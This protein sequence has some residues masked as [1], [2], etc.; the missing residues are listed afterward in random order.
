[1]R[2]SFVPPPEVREL[3]ELTRYRER[4]A[5]SREELCRHESCP[6]HA[7]SITRPTREPADQ[8]PAPTPTVSATSN[9]GLSGFDGLDH[10]DQR[11]ADSGHQFN[12]EPP[13]QALCVGA[14]FVFEA[15]NDA[16]AV[17]D[18]VGSRLAGPVSNNRF[19]GLPS[20]IV[21]SP[22]GFAFGPFVSDPRCYFDP[23]TQRWF[24]TVLELDLNPTA[25][26]FTGPSSLLIAV[27]T[28]SDPTGQF[29][30]YRLDTTDR[31]DGDCPCF[32]DFPGIGADA[33]GFYI[34][35]NEYPVSGLRPNVNKGA[36]LFA[37][38]K[39]ALESGT[40][41]PV[42][43]LAGF[44]PND[45]GHTIRPAASPGGA[46]A[47]ANGGTEY[48]VSAFPI[49]APYIDNRIN[50][51]SLTNT[52]SLGTPTPAL[53]LS[54]V[55]VTSEMTAQPAEVEQR[56]GPLPLADFIANVLQAKPGDA[57]EQHLE[58]LEGVFRAPSQV[59]YS[60]G[61]LWTAMDTEVKTP[62]GPVRMGAAW[63]VIEPS[64]ATGSLSAR[65]VNQ[66]YVA[67][68]GENVINPAIAVNDG[69][70][71]A[72]G[73][74][75]VGP[76]DFPSAAYVDL[77]AVTGTGPVHVAALGVAPEDGLTGYKPFGGLG[78]ARW[79]DYGS[80][81]AAQDGSLWL[82]TEYITPRPRSH[83]ANW[84]TFVE[85]ITR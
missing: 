85:H 35:A 4:E 53:T 3:R 42:V 20:A 49:G 6:D 43:R 34:G 31:A 60:Q 22:S 56:P 84:G 27:S 46:Y 52:G 73:F 81:V 37:M 67:V 71:A 11:F 16:V 30:T 62:T 75:L 39:L 12:L 61:K 26:A 28:T 21:V 82:A 68:D 77:D 38:S 13:D 72:L 70:G 76:E 8:L 24:Y 66:G 40:V 18:Q 17:F 5:A 69:G 63:Y 9:P 47:M 83:F 36:E 58:V 50:V 2:P 80:A 78:I 54:R 23:D 1:M 48:L 51:W 59:V 41:P 64:F 45:G 10:R 33:S 74:T 44:D 65:V 25:F 32:A 29:R 14:G 7:T 19:F 79:G 15:V 55:V 57:P